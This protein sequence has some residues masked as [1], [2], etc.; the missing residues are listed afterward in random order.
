MRCNKIRH[1]LVKFTNNIICMNLNFIDFII[2]D[3]H[4]NSDFDFDLDNTMLKLHNRPEM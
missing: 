1:F 2:R 3:G 4:K